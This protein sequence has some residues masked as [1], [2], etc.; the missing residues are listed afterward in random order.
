[1]EFLLLAKLYIAKVCYV[2][3]LGNVEL[4]SY[5]IYFSVRKGNKCVQIKKELRNFSQAS[6]LGFVIYSK[7]GNLREKFSLSKQVQQNRKKSS[8]RTY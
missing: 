3:S 7:I 8:S 1:M 5:F 6:S 4:H 2:K